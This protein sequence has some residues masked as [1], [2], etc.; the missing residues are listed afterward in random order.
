MARY[1]ASVGAATD[2]VGPRAGE[3]IRAIQPVVRGLV[4]AVCCIAPVYVRCGR[5]AAYA[6]SRAPASAIRVCVGLFL[7]FFGGRYYGVIA[8]TEAFRAYGWQRICSKIAVVAEQARSNSDPGENTHSNR[9]LEDQKRLSHSPHFCSTSNANC[10]SH[11][12]YSIIESTAT[13]MLLA[14]RAS[15]PLCRIST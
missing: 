10:Q 6:Y 1:L 13:G 2:D 5:L 4:D 9:C 14:T 3:C 7:C 15:H 12:M 11:P 8:A